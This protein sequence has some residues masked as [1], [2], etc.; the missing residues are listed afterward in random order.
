MKV[1]SS[2][3]FL[4]AITANHNVQESFWRNYLDQFK[5][6]KLISSQ[7][8][9]ISRITLIVFNYL[10]NEVAALVEEYKPGVNYEFRFNSLSIKHSTSSGVYFDQLNTR[11]LHRQK[12][13]LL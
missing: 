2:I 4:L 10:D 3:L 7:L 1:F 5:P 11:N 13:L 6:N 9:L 8:P 12:M